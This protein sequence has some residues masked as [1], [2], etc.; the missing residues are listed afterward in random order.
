MSSP[1]SIGHD[2]V[3]FSRVVGEGSALAHI[4]ALDPLSPR[5]ELSAIPRGMTATFSAG[6][7]E[8]GQAAQGGSELGKFHDKYVKNS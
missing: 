4:L 3:H 5:P 7:S 1:A 6:R 8:S 2:I